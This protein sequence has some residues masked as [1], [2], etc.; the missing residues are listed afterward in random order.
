LTPKNDELKMEGS[1]DRQLE[2][3]HYRSCLD[4]AVYQEWRGFHCRMCDDFEPEEMTQEDK[5]AFTEACLALLW[6][7]NSP[8]PR[9]GCHRFQN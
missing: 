8:L 7:V 4:H 5:L 9:I 1:V 3:K 2:C 6:A